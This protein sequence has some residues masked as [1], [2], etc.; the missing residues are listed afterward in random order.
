MVIEIF[1]CPNVTFTYFNIDA[2]I[3]TYFVVNSVKYY[4]LNCTPSYCHTDLK[5]LLKVLK[6]A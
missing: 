5:H 2:I 1:C 4:T 3:C 6:D